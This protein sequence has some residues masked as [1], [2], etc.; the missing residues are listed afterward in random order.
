MDKSKSFLELKVIW[1]DHEIIQL[2]ITASNGKFCG[3]TE[4]YEIPAC[5]YDFAEKLTNHPK[6]GEKLSYS[7][8]IRTGYDFFSMKY[9]LINDTGKLGIEI[10]IDSQSEYFVDVKDS[11]KLEIVVEPNA[12]KS[13]QKEL[14]TLAK[15]ENGKAKIYGIDSII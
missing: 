5:L 11:V 3:K 14:Q 6:S 4:M 13:F 10:I 1:N 9:Y 2:Q 12:I 7:P 15:K 8:S